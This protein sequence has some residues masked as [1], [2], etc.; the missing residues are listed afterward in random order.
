MIQLFYVPAKKKP[1]VLNIIRKSSLQDAQLCLDLSIKIMEKI[2][3]LHGTPS[4]LGLIC[5]SCPL[6][7][8]PIVKRN[9][10]IFNKIIEIKD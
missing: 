2:K 1:K 4:F 10:V 6:V 8:I 3:L 5:W 9:S 7:F